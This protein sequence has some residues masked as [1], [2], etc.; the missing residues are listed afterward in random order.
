MASFQGPTV[1]LPVYLPEGIFCCFWL[2]SQQL[3]PIMA[4]PSSL[5]SYAGTWPAIWFTVS[6]R[7]S[8]WSSAGRTPP[9]PARPTVLAARRLHQ[10][11]V[12]VQLVQ[13]V[14]RQVWYEVSIQ[15]LCRCWKMMKM[16]IE[17]KSASFTEVTDNVE[18]LDAFSALKVMLR[19]YRFSV[20]WC[21]LR[22]FE[23]KVVTFRGVLCMISY[24]YH[25]IYQDLIML[26]KH[27]VFKPCQWAN[28]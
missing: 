9:R 25:K 23:E 10:Q 24:S 22:M 16:L 18:V 1:Y 17:T 26:K 4:P 21:G 14:L 11:K 19:A 15:V 20:F 7:R 6:P 8:H 12:G 2:T 3:R 28:T 5:P 27:V 13:N